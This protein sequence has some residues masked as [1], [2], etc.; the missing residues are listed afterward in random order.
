MADDS[1]TE[2]EISDKNEENGLVLICQY[3]GKVFFYCQIEKKFSFDDISKFTIFYD[4]VYCVFTL[5]RQ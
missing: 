5:V 4:F 1:G 3:D 2:F